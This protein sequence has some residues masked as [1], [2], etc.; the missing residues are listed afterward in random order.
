[1]IKILILAATIMFVI[2]SLSHGQDPNKNIPA[3]Y[4]ALKNPLQASPVFN[5]Q[6]LKIYNKACWVCHGD[7]G[8]GNGPNSKDIKT[9]VADFKNPVVK[10]RSD[11]A[12]F[13]WIH[14]GGNDM[15]PFKDILTDEEIWKLVIYIRSVQNEVAQ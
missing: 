9:V 13:W 2:P 12:L 14:V 10:G 1:M 6:G 7:N 5:K 11:G 15:E 8:K 4:K 3:Q